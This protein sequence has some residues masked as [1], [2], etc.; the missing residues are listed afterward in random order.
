MEF[1]GNCLYPQVSCRIEGDV[2]GCSY[3]H[4]IRCRQFSAADHASNLRVDS[5]AITWQAGE[6]LVRCYKLSNQE[7]C[8]NEFCS[9]VGFIFLAAGSLVHEISV[10][11]SDHNCSASRASWSCF[12][13]TLLRH[14]EYAG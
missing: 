3:C 7:R 5:Q 13:H 14:D 8:R 4:C 12:D 6:P 1:W 2:I 9:E 10:V 11:P